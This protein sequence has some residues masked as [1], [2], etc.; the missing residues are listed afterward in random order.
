M[1]M[2]PVMLAGIGGAAVPLVLHLLSRARHR[3]VAWGAMMFLEPAGAAAGRIARLREWAIVVLR[4]AM[5]ALVAVALARPVF[6]ESAEPAGR[7]V[8]LVMD[9][10]ARMA[11][12]EGGRPRMDL[13]R[14]A[15]LRELS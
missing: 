2:N 7:T 11:I 1:F 8:V 6:G 14:E 5:V 12:D 9:C 10:S 4:M 3:E 15:A 13:G